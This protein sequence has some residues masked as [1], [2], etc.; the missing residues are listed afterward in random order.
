MIFWQPAEMKDS[1]P[2]HSLQIGYT[3]WAT[4]ETS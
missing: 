4:A 1:S 3:P 2:K